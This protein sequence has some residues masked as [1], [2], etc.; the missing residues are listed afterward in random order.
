MMLTEKHEDKI[1]GVLYCYDRVIINEVA[2][3]WGSQVA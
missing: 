3:T 2:G 1:E